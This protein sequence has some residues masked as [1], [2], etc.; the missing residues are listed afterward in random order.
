[1]ADNDDTK[2]R[3]G[4]F[5]IIRELGRGG[6]GVVY[7]ARQVS[8]NRNV[9]LK[10]ISGS[11]GLSSKAVLRF[12]RE[13]EA[14][15]KLHHTNIVPIYATGE[16]DGTHYYA[17][18]L[19]DGPSL[20][21]VIGSIRR[22]QKDDSA[23]A[24]SQKSDGG[25][26]AQHLGLSSILGELPSWVTDTFAGQADP[27][28]G[29][30][31]SS[32]SLTASDSS[33]SLQSGTHYFD[34]VARMIAEVADALDHAHENGVIHR[35]I[36]PANLLLAPD[37]HLSVTDFGLARML[38]QPGM[39]MSGEFVGSPLYMSP[40]QITAG[41][42]PLDHRTDIFSLGSTLDE[43]LTLAPPFPGRGRDE[44]MARILQKEPRRPRSV[45]K[46]VPVDLETICLKALEK[47]PDQRYQTAGQLAEDLR[48]FMNRFAIAARRMG[49]IGRV[50]K[51]ARRR[52]AMAGLLICSLVAALLGY[53]LYLSEKASRMAQGEAALNQARAEI[54]R[55]RFDRVETHLERAEQ[56]HVDPG[57]VHLFRGIVAG[58][59]GD[60]EKATKE[61]ERA[62]AE[63]PESL[64][65]KSLLHSCYKGNGRWE[66]ASLL[67]TEVHA[68]K[69]ITPEDYLYGALIISG[70]LRERLAWIEKIASEQRA[71]LAELFRGELLA[72]ELRKT[73]NPDDIEEALAP[74][75]S[76]RN[77]MPSNVRAASSFVWAHLVATDI[78]KVRNDT[79]HYGEYLEKAKAV[80]SEL[81][82]NHEKS[83]G[84]YS[85]NA[86]LAVYEEDFEAAA[87]YIRDGMRLGRVGSGRSHSLTPGGFLYLQGRSLEEILKALEGMPPAA[88]GA[89][90]WVRDRAFVVAEHLGIEEAEK[91]YTDWLLI[92]HPIQVR[93]Y[94]S[95]PYE[96]FQFLGLPEKATN[97]ATDFLTQIGKP[98]G[99]MGAFY[100][101]MD[102][103]VCG[104]S[105]ATSLLKAASARRRY[106]IHARYL[107]G[108]ERFSEGDRRGAI[109]Q[110][111]QAEQEGSFL[112]HDQLW[113]AAMLK[114]LRDD[115]EWPRWIPVKDPA[116]A[117]HK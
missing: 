33:S 112:F 102:D 113:V 77:M 70:S 72:D 82:K 55:G 4:D 83:V 117:S 107:I 22:E 28:S 86:L 59:A 110:F 97:Y 104:E 26:S 85:A 84:T 60:R 115:P 91:T 73:Y 116:D 96:I 87:R 76:A 46:K 11:L 74:L 21:Q 75:V 32:S 45:N 42:V 8:L 35:D 12:Q 9:A 15:G 18:E 47:D 103:F 99:K 52:P 2:K 95:I 31:A 78:Y 81:L 41:R 64:A 24:A 56:F 36:K 16:D 58:E 5:E 39:T 80:A 40:E 92:R 50:V 69:P 68:M 65:A 25:S 34:T 1:M 30:S 6:M 66:D 94:R 109:E 98:P 43:L 19:I 105:S 7:E 88:K 71:P 101:A 90:T 89:P 62:V 61:L 17:M 51:W 44:V 54:F 100:E 57:R 48:R 38:E 67:Y 108:L 111:E 106:R 37:G 10:V 13:A 20:R 23:D 114:R 63:S 53:G 29:S 3:L 79:A 14:A 49:P 27:G 93:R